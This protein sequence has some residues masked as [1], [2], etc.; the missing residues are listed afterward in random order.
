MILTNLMKFK[1][2]ATTKTRYVK[3]FEAIDA[4][5]AERQAEDILDWTDAQQNGQPHRRSAVWDIDYT[6]T[7]AIDLVEPIYEVDGPDG[8]R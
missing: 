3:V 7:S 5:D 1:V 2:Y 4:A 8:F 6:H